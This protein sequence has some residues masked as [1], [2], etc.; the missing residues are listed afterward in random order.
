MKSLAIVFSGFCWATCAVLMLAATPLADAAAPNPL[1]AGFLAP[2]D[3]AKPMFRWWWFGP[4]VEKPEILRELSQ[5]KADGVGGAEMAFVYPET[6]DDPSKNLVNET[7]VGP[8][9]LDNVRY[10]Q[11][12][13]RLLGLRIDVTLGSGWPYGGPATPLREAAG[14]L[15]TLEVAVP[16]GAT[17]VAMP[18]MEEGD[19]AIASD[20]ADGVPGKWDA[21]SAKP[22]FGSF[23]ASAAPRVALFFIGGHTRQTVKR[24][25]VGA[26]G[27][28]LDPFSKAA[29]DTHLKA[30]G[31]PLLS[32]FGATPPYAIFSDSLEAYGA[33]WTPDLPA[34]FRA[35]RGYDLV[36][37]LPELVA[38]GTPVAE[39]VRHDWGRTLTELVNE[40]YL[41]PVT[42]F[43]HA[44][45][46]RFRSQTYG[47]PAV[48]LSSQ[49]IPDLA[50]GEAPQWREFSTLRWATSGNHVFGHT[51]TSAETF[52]WLHS[53]VFRATPLD[54][55]VEVDR[56]FLIGTNQVIG[57]GWPYSAP[58]AGEPG[59]SLYAAAVFNDHNPWH[60]VMPAVA[61]YIQRISHMLRQ[62]KPANQVAVLLPTDDAWAGFMPGHVTVTGLMPKLVS[63]Q[64]MA[65]ILDGG[66]NI[67]Y[68][69]ADAI[70]AVGIHY[71]LLVLPPTDR[72]P[73]ATL[74]AIDRYV[75]NG[76]KVVAV[77]RA[78]SL[79]DAGQVG[80]GLLALSHKLFSRQAGTL[81]DVGG[82]TGALNHMLTP[83][84][85]MTGGPGAIGF[86]RRTLTGG[87]IYFIA[88]TSNTPV[89][90]HI[91]LASTFAD[92]QQWDPDS[93]VATAAARAMDLQLAPYESRLFVFG[94]GA[95]KPAATSSKMLADL[96]MDWR[97][98]FTGTGRSVQEQAPA[99][100]TADPATRT[101]S[102][103]A[104]YEKSFD[105]S[106][107]PAHA[108]LAVEGGGPEAVNI[109]DL[110]R[111]N[112]GTRA[113]YDPPVRE[114]ALVLVNGKK[115]GALWHPP[116]RLDVGRLLHAGR[117]RIAIKVY[118]TAINAWVAL[119]PRDYKPL[120]AQYGDRF[121]MQDLDK[122]KP[123]PSGLL[124]KVVLQG[125]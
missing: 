41:K 23:A 86:I 113:F 70:K 125:G 50:E 17:S 2:P 115:A 4:A 78:P 109:P 5:M 118:N 45:N 49:N 34:Q 9:M 35:R 108:W 60:P 103:E 112:P 3:N 100:W 47:E 89:A 99:D 61:R 54:M 10:A 63:P 21:A 15:K 91:R 27:W 123:V 46:T 104:V 96:G 48:T 64:F 16:A 56:H 55:K 57:H 68:I 88:N 8:A 67:D 28:V 53:P 7:F 66:Y 32:A 121:H 71:P 31:E 19:Y 81:V 122:V 1:Y 92:G 98:R 82:L 102:G 85:Q 93:G 124:G 79:D 74:Q 117:N 22:F 80:A 52:T 20:L 101:Y 24:A 39:Q 59:W 18:P 44:H 114:A 62:G 90:A 94:A 83:D 6:L 111:P 30:V 58:A 12:Q 120:I 116:Y 38:G 51:V 110:G 40:A 65:S 42:D 87:D 25:S 36:A 43:A 26:E 76:G 105:L 97:V 14:K 33:D 73:L 69:D 106:A 75:A 29:T 77:G 95:A 107:A 119:P 84:L 11:E 37:R 13:A 72:I